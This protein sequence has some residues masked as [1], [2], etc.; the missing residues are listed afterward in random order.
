[1]ELGQRF[2]TLCIQV[3]MEQRCV[4]KALVKLLALINLHEHELATEAIVFSY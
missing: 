4:D 2:F 1:M 3:L